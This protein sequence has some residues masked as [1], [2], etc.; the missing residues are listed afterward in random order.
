LPRTTALRTGHGTASWCRAIAFTSRTRF[1]ARDSND[2]FSPG[3]R[4]FQRNT[5]PIFKIRAAVGSAFA[6]TAPSAAEN[7]LYIEKILKN[8]PEI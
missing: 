2:C 7:T 8:I 3:G 5:Q 6:R 1:K 4:F